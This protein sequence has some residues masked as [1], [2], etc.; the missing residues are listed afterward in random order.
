MLNF[1][2]SGIA[3]LREN[4]LSLEDFGIDPDLAG[5]PIAL[6]FTPIY[7]ISPGS[8]ATTLTSG[9]ENYQK[10]LNT[11]ADYFKIDDVDKVDDFY[12]NQ[13]TSSIMG[14]TASPSD[15]LAQVDS[16]QYLANFNAPPTRENVADAW[17][18]IL[19][20]S[21][22]A[23]TAAALSE[24]YGYEIQPR[25]QSLGNFGGN[26]RTH[27][28]SSK[29]QLEEFHS[30]VE[31][32]LEEQIPFLQVTE[33]LSYQD[34]LLESYNRDPML[35][36][37]YQKYGVTPVRQTKDGSTYLY[38][39]FSYS[40][41]RTVEVKDT[42]VQDALKAVAIMVATA[43]AG[44]AL[45]GYLAA[46][47]SMSAPLANAVG[48]A[49]ASAGST[50]ATGGDTSD[51]LRSAV[52]AG[53][54]GYA[55]GLQQVAETSQALA[56]AGAFSAQSSQLAAEAAKAAKDLERFN[57]VVKTAKFVDAAVNEDVLGGL[58]NLYGAEFTGKAL[59]K[60]GLDQE[61]LDDKYGGIQRDDMTAGLVKM[62]QRLAGGADFEDALMDGFGTYIREGGTLGF[63]VDTPEFIEQIGDAIKEA[64][65]QFDDYILQPPK[66]AIEELVEM[67]PDVDIPE[68]DIPDLPSID[69]PQVDLP[70]IDLPQVD[71]PSVDLPQVD[72]PSIDLPQV[73]LPSVDL[74]QVDLPSID[75][76][77]VDAPSIDVPSVDLPSVDLDL[78]LPK[79]DFT[80]FEVSESMLGDY[81][82]QYTTPGLL[83]RRKLRAYTAPG[84]FRGMI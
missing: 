23:D 41:I 74:P 60:L 66:E 75:T 5:T 24:H 71:L 11:G 47:T 8:G 83:E 40:E 56:G 55:E 20:P 33:G 72:L 69:L 34:A 22:A 67:I 27:T 54:G 39:P 25:D 82:K 53:A 43:G 29:E 48:A 49:V 21:N 15:Y 63:D 6:G 76:A 50:A 38:D 65:R 14:M 19:I 13:F 4:P 73:D 36:A 70:S 35:Q 32:I 78:D 17:G 81:K 2:F 16:P 46:S 1:D 3:N 57:N 26:L 80:P 64:G 51:I 42:G 45:G 59:D 79:L 28:R 62:Q 12:D 7:S 31:P 61:T 68:V 30:L 10:S 84:M 37:L 9:I 52:L 77:S 44:S 58:V 18:K